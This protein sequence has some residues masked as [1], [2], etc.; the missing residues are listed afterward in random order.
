[1]KKK[2]KTVKV[3]KKVPK[4]PKVRVVRIETKQVPIKVSKLKSTRSTRKDATFGLITCGCGAIRPWYP[5]LSPEDDAKTCKKCRGASVSNT[6]NAA[7]ERT[8]AR[9]EQLARYDRELAQNR[10]VFHKV[11]LQEETDPSSNEVEKPR[12][13]LTYTPKAGE[14]VHATGR[15][16]TAKKPGVITRILELLRGAS[17]KKPITKPEIL[18]DL[19]KTF[20][21]RDPK[22]MMNTINSQVPSCLWTE[23]KIKAQTNGKGGWWTDD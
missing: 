8:E 15:P 4:A 17:K 13:K 1:M 20:K 23:K 6:P 10:A 3:K 11:P 16:L 18:E 9:V 2:T 7:P 21:G 5:N 14:Q 19:K 22:A 12:P